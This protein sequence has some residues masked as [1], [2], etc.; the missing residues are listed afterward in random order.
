MHITRGHPL[1][2]KIKANMAGCFGKTLKQ[3]FPFEF[4][5]APLERDVF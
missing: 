5:S 4:L 1:K 2:I 3:Y